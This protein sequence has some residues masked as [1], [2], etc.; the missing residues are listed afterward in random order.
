LL[1][2]FQRFDGSMIASDLPRSARSQLSV[3]RSA[4]GVF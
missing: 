2:R 3:G 1:Q 4:F